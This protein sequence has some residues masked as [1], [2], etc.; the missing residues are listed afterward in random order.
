MSA[1]TQSDALAKRFE[2]IVRPYSQADVQKLR[3]SVKKIGRAHV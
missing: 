2:G 3:G 1:V